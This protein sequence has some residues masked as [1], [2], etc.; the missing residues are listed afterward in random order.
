[1]SSTAEQTN[2]GLSEA[3]RMLKVW[4]DW[5]RTGGR[6]LCRGYPKA[7]AFTHAD[8]VRGTCDQVSDDNPEALAVENAMCKLKCINK[9]AF[10]ALIYEYYMELTNREASDKL[11]CSEKTYKHRRAMGEH[12]IAGKVS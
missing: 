11:K 8:E 6:G 10:M 5:L 7:S 4:A 12:F 1:M 2:D 9:Q 3:R